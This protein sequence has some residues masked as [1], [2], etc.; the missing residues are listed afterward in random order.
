[1]TWLRSFVQR[2][3]GMRRANTAL[4]NHAERLNKT[5]GHLVEETGNYLRDSLYGVRRVQNDG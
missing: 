3:R 5:Q 1:M 4:I 2:I